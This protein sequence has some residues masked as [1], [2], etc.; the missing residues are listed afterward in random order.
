MHQMKQL[1]ADEK[2]HRL[3][4]GADYTHT[5]IRVTMK[6]GEKYTLDMSGA[7]YG[8]HECI[9]PW[10][11]YKSSRVRKVKEVVPFGHI[12]V[13]CKTRASKMGKK[14]EWCHGIKGNFATSMDEAVAWWQR[15]NISSTD[16]LRLPEDE[17]QKSQASLLRC[18]DE[19]L[20]RYKVFQE[21]KG[22]LDVRGDLTHEAYDRAFIN[23][24]LGDI[25]GR[26]PP[27][28]ERPDRRFQE[29]GR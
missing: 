23:A 19:L 24:A 26:R 3:I 28:S 16:L 8:W 14:Q 1:Y 4:D 12:K 2:F 15:S 13:F 7:Q 17:F 11:L 10:Q 5:I 9:T 29:C 18:V 6:N 22:A 27:S 20:Q 25:L 21:S